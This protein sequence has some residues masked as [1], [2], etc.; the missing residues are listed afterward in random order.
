MPRPKFGTER[1]SVLL[2]RYSPPERSERDRRGR[3]SAFRELRAYDD[4]RWPKIDTVSATG[5]ISD[6]P[7]DGN[8][9]PAGSSASNRSCNNRHVQSAPIP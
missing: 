3:E 6:H 9:P 4:V 7:G 1:L 2:S 8:P 5:T